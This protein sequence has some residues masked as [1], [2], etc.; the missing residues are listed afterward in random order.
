MLKNYLKLSFLVVVLFFVSKTDVQAQTV[1]VINGTISPQNPQ[2]YYGDNMRF[3]YQPKTGYELDSVIVNGVSKGKDSLWYYTL[4]NINYNSSL[5]VVFKRKQFGIAQT[6]IIKRPNLSDSI[7][8]KFIGTKAPIDLPIDF[9]D[10]L[11]NSNVT[12][13]EGAI[14]IDT[15]I[16]DEKYKLTTKPIGAQPWAG[17]TIGDVSVNMGGLATNLPNDQAPI[18]TVFMYAPAANIPVNLKIENKSDATKSVETKD[19]T[20]IAG[21]QT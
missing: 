20:T 2:V 1:Q 18:I 10:L 17:T 3:N 11:V 16:D 9:N 14:T 12:D 19:T 21:W 15:T 4:T 5:R 13:F 6:T 8:E 7:I